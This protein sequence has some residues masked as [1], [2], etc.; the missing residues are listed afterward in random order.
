[1]DPSP[2]GRGKANYFISEIIPQTE[3]LRSETFILIIPIN[4]YDVEQGY[5]H[6]N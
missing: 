2:R 5:K 1:V 3:N 4:Q 6:I